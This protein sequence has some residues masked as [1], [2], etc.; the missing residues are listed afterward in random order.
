MTTQE[1]ETIIVQY[2]MYRMSSVESNHKLKRMFC[3]DEADIRCRKMS[4]I[5]D[6]GVDEYIALLETARHSETNLET[7]GLEYVELYSATV[8]PRGSYILAWLAKEENKPMIKKLLSAGAT[9]H[10]ELTI[11]VCG[12]LAWM[13]LSGVLQEF[14]GRKMAKPAFS[15]HN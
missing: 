11:W 12:Q 8:V 4:P 5:R 13:Y 6:I 1:E 7:R 2:Q 9:P 10:E 15:V 3:I 14:Q